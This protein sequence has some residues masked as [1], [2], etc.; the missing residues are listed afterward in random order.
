MASLTFF[1]FNLNLATAFYFDTA[2]INNNQVSIA[3]WTAPESTEDINSSLA[4][5]Q[6]SQAFW[7]NIVSHD[8]VSQIIKID[9][10]YSYG[11]LNDYK[12]KYYKTLTASLG[13]FTSSQDVQTRFL[14]TSPE[15]DGH[16]DIAF[17][18][19][20]SAGNLESL[21]QSQTAG[22]NVVSLDVDTTPPVT[23]L[24]LGDSGSERFLAQDQ[25]IHGSFEEADTTGFSWGTIAG[26]QGLVQD[27][28]LAHQGDYAFSL[29]FDS[30]Q[31]PSVSKDYLEKQY[32][33]TQPTWL[34][35][36]W[37][38]ISEDYIDFDSFLVQAKSQTK[39]VDIL[40]Y[41][42]DVTDPPSDTGWQETSY[43]FDSGWLNHIFNLR[44][45]LINGLDDRYPT[46]VLVDDVRLIPADSQ[47][48]ADTKE[49][50][51]LPKDAS[52]SGVVKVNVCLEN[53][54]QEYNYD[55]L[56]SET[57]TIGPVPAGQAVVLN[58]WSQDDL[59]HLEA[60]KSAV[61]AVKDNTTDNMIGQL[62]S[63]VNKNIVLNQ[64]LVDPDGSAGQG[65]DNDDMPY[66]EW[67][68][69]FNRHPSLV[70]DLNQWY[71]VDAA[72]NQIVF[73]S[74]RSI[75]QTTLVQPLSSLRF[76]LNKAV[77]NNNQDTIS[78]YDNVGLLIDQISYDQVVIGKTWKRQP[79]GFG[80]WMDPEPKID[81]VNAKLVP[82][83]NPVSTES[84]VLIP[85]PA[86]ATAGAKPALTG[87]IDKEAKEASLSAGLDPKPSQTPIPA[88][89]AKPA[90][91]TV[92]TPSP[93]PL[94]T[95]E[96][97]KI[98]P[99]TKDGKPTVTAEDKAS[100]AQS[101][102]ESETGTTD[103]QTSPS[104]LVPDDD[105]DSGLTTPIAIPIPTALPTPTDK[106]VNQLSKT[107]ERD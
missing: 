36:W 6:S 2:I 31:A 35:F 34:S 67:V 106:D 96:S 12:F 105:V 90:V 89:T 8:D 56:V 30:S 104:D 98:E 92:Q 88:G 22:F 54:C 51:L 62:D 69:V 19:T 1:A 84:G 26:S 9:V 5:W 27:Q 3:D 11:N 97:Q 72:G 53:N 4:L 94:P 13:D 25:E 59:G 33:L 49:L 24:S 83:S 18:A 44:F 107:D 57:V 17:V 10:Y 87:G 64:F 71:I 55:G 77:L 23:A 75:S 46:Q 95:E 41:G 50:A 39:T 99:A 48:L 61:L 81:L 79:D 38:Y 32:L 82:D 100:Q 70:I 76:Y 73:D 58:Y 45:E 102:S 16:Y 63:D 37:R 68:E 101:Q 86:I 28:S 40:Q 91:T 93:T 66:G 85:A 47:F 74:T 14:F 43:Y 42:L 78:L 80:S 103:N 65:N 52:G 20:D 15:G 29:G 7:V 60:T 21:P